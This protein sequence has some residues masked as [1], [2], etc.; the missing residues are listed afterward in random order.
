MLI[1]T[2]SSPCSLSLSNRSTLCSTKK[3][4]QNKSDLKNVFVQ[5]S[6]FFN[7]YSFDP[8]HAYWNQRR[9]F[10]GRVCFDD[11]RAGNCAQ[12]FLL[13]SIRSSLFTFLSFLLQNPKLWFRALVHAPL[14]LLRCERHHALNSFTI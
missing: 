14:Q 3:C 8:N 10:C 12:L 2:D 11:C 6:F 13:H 1:G 5:K 9:L 7:I 4:H